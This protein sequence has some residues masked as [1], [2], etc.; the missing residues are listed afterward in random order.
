[1]ASGLDLARGAREQRDLDAVV[2]LSLSAS[3]VG[4][5]L[6]LWIGLVLAIGVWRVRRTELK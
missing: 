3:A 5:S 2:E 1:V 4:T 6:A